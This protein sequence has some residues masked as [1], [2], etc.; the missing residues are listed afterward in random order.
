MTDAI[1]TDEL[2]QCDGS[3]MSNVL[4][5]DVVGVINDGSGTV[6]GGVL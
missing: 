2:N 4:S 1:V 5:D 6:M 3:G